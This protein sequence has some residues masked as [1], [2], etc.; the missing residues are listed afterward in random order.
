MWGRFEERGETEMEIF[1]HAKTKKRVTQT[2]TA[3]KPR[4]T[5]EFKKNYRKSADPVLQ[6]HVEVKMIKTYGKY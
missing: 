3:N 5:E 6:I 2:N 1:N 4:E